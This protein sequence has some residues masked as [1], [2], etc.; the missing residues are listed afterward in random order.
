MLRAIGLMLLL[1]SPAFAGAPEEP[2]D[3]APTGRFR[4][5][6][7]VNEQA[8]AALVDELG[9]GFAVYH[10]D[11][12][13]IAHDADQAGARYRGAILESVYSAFTGFFSDAG[14]S[15]DLPKSL[16]PVV[17]FPTRDAFR[18]HLAEVGLSEQVDGLYV[19]AANRAYFFKGANR[20][21]GRDVS[22][23]T[24]RAMGF[25]RIK[26]ATAAGV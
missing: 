15:L 24:L 6:W 18:A 13:S 9:D 19:H 20:S 10:G 17:L 3:P 4:E 22:R 11:H 21:E 5:I 1:A 25:N 2:W 12:F 26:G 23:T 14:F 7:P 16:L 8:D